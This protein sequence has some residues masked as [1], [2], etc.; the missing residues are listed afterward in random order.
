MTKLIKVIGLSLLLQGCGGL[1]S[2]LKAYKDI[3]KIYQLL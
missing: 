2:N 1:G 3:S